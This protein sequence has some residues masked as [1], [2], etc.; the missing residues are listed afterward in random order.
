MLRKE[1]NYG[2]GQSPSMR[3][4]WIEMFDLNNVSGLLN[5]SLHAEGVD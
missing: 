2:L 3:R 4:E 5:V 1:L